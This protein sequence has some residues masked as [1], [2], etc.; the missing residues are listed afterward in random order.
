MEGGIIY[1]IGMSRGQQ[2]ILCNDN[3]GHVGGLLSLR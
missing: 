2:G 3:E 1:I